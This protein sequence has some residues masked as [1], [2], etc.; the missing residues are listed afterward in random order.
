MSTRCSWPWTGLLIVVALLP[1]AGRVT[2]ARADGGSGRI[3]GVVAA[4]AQNQLPTR[5]TINADLGSVVLTLTPDT[6]F[7]LD[8]AAAPSLADNPAQ[9]AGRFVE[10]R[11]DPATNIASSVEVDAKF[12]DSGAVLAISR[13]VVPAALTIDSAFA[14]PLTIQVTAATDVTADF[15]EVTDLNALRNEMVWVAYD[16][17]MLVASQVMTLPGDLRLRG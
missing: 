3:L 4:V 13:P 9:L 1:A 15:E 14:G 6:S 2:T 5:V 17:T 16:P 12:Q 10:V 11:F 8:G 7:L